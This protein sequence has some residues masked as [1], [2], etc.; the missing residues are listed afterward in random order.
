MIVTPAW[1]H[2]SIVSTASST[3]FCNVSCVDCS[4]CRA[5]AT[6]ASATQSLASAYSRA[7]E[8]NN[9]VNPVARRLHMS[10]DD[11]RGHT[12]ASPIPD[13]PVIRVRG[14]GSTGRVATE[15]AAATSDALVTYTTTLNRT[16]EDSNRLLSQYRAISEKVSREQRRV[17]GLGRNDPRS[18]GLAAAQAQLATDTLQARSLSGAFQSS[19]QGRGSSKL[20]GVLTEA[21]SAS[22]DR[23]Q[24]LQLLGLAGALAGLLVGVALATLRASG[25]ARRSLLG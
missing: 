11:V 17:D 12:S 10:P 20:V 24:K 5:L 2:P 21:T 8:A 3:I 15:L 16:S 18:K 23:M 7:V 14:T 22:S 4:D 6:F 9:V 19:E 1:W 13:S 25:R